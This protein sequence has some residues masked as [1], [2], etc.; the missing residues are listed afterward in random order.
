[1]TTVGPGRPSLMVQRRAE[2]VDSFIRLVADR[3]LEDVTLD[4]IAV[5][6]KLQRSSV[7]HFV[8]NRRALINAAIIEL[9]DRYAASVRAGLGGSLGIDELIAMTFSRGWLEHMSEISCALDA[10]IQEAARDDEIAAHVRRAYDVFL[11]GV[12]GALRREFPTAP[13]S[14]V[15]ETAY[16]IMCLVEHNTLLQRLGFSTSLSKGA[17]KSARELA[18]AL[19][20]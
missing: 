9:S 15:R 18:G 19:G 3:G 13:A 1:M 2:I 4:D 6:A 5:D 17:A 10:L 11:T 16:A 20:S 14:R 12:Q 8:G 7:R